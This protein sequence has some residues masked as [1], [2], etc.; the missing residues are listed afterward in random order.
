MFRLR[1]LPWDYGIRNLFRRPGRSALTLGAPALVV[2]LV[3]LVVGF[4]RGLET[5]LAVSGDRRVVLVHA[6][7]TSE[8]ME[9]SSVPGRTPGLLAASLDSIQRRYGAA[10]ISPEVYLGTRVILGD[11]DR[12]TL[13]LVRGVLP[14]ALLVR[15]QVQLTEGSWPGPGEL[16][17]GR[18]AAT[19]LGREEQALE[20]GQS[21]HF[22]GRTW[23]ISG[24][25]AAAGSALEAELW[26]PL[27]DLQ[28][29]LKR[30]D[31]T[32]AAVTLA[33]GAS[34]A[35]IDEFCKERL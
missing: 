7:G 15:R 17:A 29:T 18:L 27:D 35:D 30:Q 2:L 11:N 14:A 5:S 33:P 8:N 10:Y 19:K 22:E 13:G 20:V 24:R 6:L 12:Q 21:I 23:R 31:L 4:L 28:Q 25:F 9:T 1:L 3:L 32:L 26:C 34:F 16:L